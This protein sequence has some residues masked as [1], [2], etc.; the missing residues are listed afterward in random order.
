MIDYLSANLWQ[1]WAVVAVLCLITELSTGGFFVLCFAIGAVGAA[2]C[3]VFGGL[4]LQ[5]TAFVA[6]SIACIFLVRPFALKYLHFGK[7]VAVSNADAIIGRTG[8]V[9]QAIPLGGY[10]RVAID[11]D[12]WKA[13]SSS[14]IATIPEGSC[15]NVVARESIIIDV[16]L[17]THN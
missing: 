1:V 2:F 15:V 4:Y 17:I 8:R 10:G 13:Q 7:E 9:S 14:A 5:L 3:S 11:G 16:T 12:D 6:I